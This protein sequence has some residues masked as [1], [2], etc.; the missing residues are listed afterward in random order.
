MDSTLN[1]LAAKAARMAAEA[2]R[3]AAAAAPAAPNDSAPVAVADEIR[4]PNGR[5]KWTKNYGG[6]VKFRVSVVADR[7]GSWRPNSSNV[8]E[9]LYESSTRL[10]GASESSLYCTKPAREKAGK[11]A[12]EFN[13]RP[14]EERAARYA[15]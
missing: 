14:A 8:L 13:A 6:V 11:I 9:I 3:M 7:A 15:Q 1:N 12:A 4:C 2:A 10:I 5:F